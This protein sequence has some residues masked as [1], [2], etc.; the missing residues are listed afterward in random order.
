MLEKLFPV[1]EQHPES[2]NSDQLSG[3]HVLNFVRALPDCSEATEQDAQHWLNSDSHD[4]GWQLLAQYELI[5]GEVDESAD[6]EEEEAEKHDDE[7]GSEDGEESLKERDALKSLQHVMDWYQTTWEWT[8]DS[9]RLF[10]Y[11]WEYLVT[12]VLSANHI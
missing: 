10:Q 11:I 9:M 2:A 1:E 8:P 5:H 12:D 7:R 3:R 6:E 4:P